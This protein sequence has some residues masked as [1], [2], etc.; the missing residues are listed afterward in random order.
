MTGQS[1]LALL[2]IASL[3]ALNA[4]AA[5]DPAARCTQARL[6]ATAKRA[7]GELKCHATAAAKGAAV[8]PACLAKAATKFSAAWARA[9]SKG[10]CAPL[11]EENTIGNQVKACVVNLTTSFR[12]CGEVDGVCGGTCPSGLNCFAIGVGCFG[13]IEPCR[14]HGSTTTCPT[15]SSSTSTS[16][17]TSTTLP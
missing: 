9:Q 7:D 6:K 14:C 1:T 8:D 2:G 5:T 15:T 16:S 3:L 13:E 17:T 10:G 12:S 4:G 11:P